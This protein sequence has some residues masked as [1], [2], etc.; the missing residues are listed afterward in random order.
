MNGYDWAKVEL[1]KIAAEL[2]GRDD[3]G[4]GAAALAFEDDPNES[5][6]LCGAG[7]FSQQNGE[8]L[9]VRNEHDVRKKHHVYGK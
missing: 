5:A 4:D 3:P 9:G 7:A 1:R 2:D 8:N 6:G